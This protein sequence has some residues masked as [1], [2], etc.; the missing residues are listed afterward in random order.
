MTSNN[1]RVEVCTAEKTILSNSDI[2][3]LIGDRCDGVVGQLTEVRCCWDPISTALS[4]RATHMVQC[5]LVLPDLITKPQHPKDSTAAVAESGAMSGMNVPRTVSSM[6]V[7]ALHAAMHACIGVSKQCIR[8]VPTNSCSSGPGAVAQVL[9]AC[10]SA[11]PGS[12][13]QSSRTD[14]PSPVLVACDSVARVAGGL[15]PRGPCS[16]T[17]HAA[18]TLQPQAGNIWKHDMLTVQGWDA[19]LF[20]PLK[21][22]GGRAFSNYAVGISNVDVDAGTA[23]KIAVGNTPGETLA[24]RSRTGRTGSMQYCAPKHESR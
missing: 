1:C 3:Q 7:I 17:A 4:M 16:N 23:N 22:A 20:E 18:G 21:A 24:A 6:G 10:I 9:P 11:A 19:D 8:N 5:S 13:A 15:P 12:A 14:R 2:K